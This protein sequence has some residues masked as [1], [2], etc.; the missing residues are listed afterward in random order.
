MS[1]LTDV[2]N[3]PDILLLGPGGPSLGSED[4]GRRQA[5]ERGRS[6][7]AWLGGLGES[8]LPCMAPRPWTHWEPREVLESDQSPALSPDHRR[9]QA[10]AGAA[11]RSREACGARC[12]G[13]GP[14]AG[15]TWVLGLALH[16]P[17]RSPVTP[18]A[19]GHAGKETSPQAG[20]RAL[21]AGLGRLGGAE[22]EAGTLIWARGGRV[23]RR[24]CPR[25]SPSGHREEHAQG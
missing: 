9:S 14:P 11:R 10:A 8:G 19:C 6:E 7:K 22:P 12:E 3:H 5:E 17:R 1:T 24:F 16:T 4:G 13:A 25:R 15:A 2:H 23:G 21:G 18:E 20:A